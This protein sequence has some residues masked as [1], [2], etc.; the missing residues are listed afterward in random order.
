M[1]HIGGGGGEREGEREEWKEERERV[2]YGLL[3]IAQNA[4]KANTLMQQTEKALAHWKVFQVGVF[5]FSFNR[6]RSFPH[7]STCALAL[8]TLIEQLFTAPRPLILQQ[9]P[10][11]SHH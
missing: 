1:W 5:H 11:L 2:W 8:D 6:L 4:N 9:A 10:G 3:H 7:I